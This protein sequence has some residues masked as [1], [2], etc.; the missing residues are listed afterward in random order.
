MWK[1]DTNPYVIFTC[2]KCKHYMYAKTT[3]KSKK[4]LRCG[5]Q[6]TVSSIIISG[7]IV[8]GMTKAVDLVK[9]R[10]N[11]LAIKELGTLPEFRAAEDF[12]VKG[13]RN[14]SINFEVSKIDDDAISG[15]FER[16]L[17]EISRSYTEF[18]YYVFEI[19]A[20]NFGIPL[21]ELKVLVKVYQKKGMFT[22]K[23]S[24]YQIHL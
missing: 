17:Q 16:M 13:Q 9:T 12:T 14:N 19:M 24:L 4:C 8:E 21:P 5:R 23:N 6:H 7:E 11:E 22:R 3:Q 20:E 15:K 10:Q 18:P 2:R 1:K